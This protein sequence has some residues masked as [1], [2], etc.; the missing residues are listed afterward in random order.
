MQFLENVFAM[1]SLAL[2]SFF[3]VMARRLDDVE[4][5]PETKMILLTDSYIH[6][7]TSIS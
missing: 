5:L 6:H 7:D 3:Q 4:P 2:H 1:V